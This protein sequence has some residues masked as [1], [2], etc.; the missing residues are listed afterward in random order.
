MEML[1]EGLKKSKALSRGLFVSYIH[2][3]KPDGI[4]SGF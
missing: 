3:K 1:L 2:P 4:P